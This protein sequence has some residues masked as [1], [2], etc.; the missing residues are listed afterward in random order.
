MYTEITAQIEFKNGLVIEDGELILGP[1]EEPHELEDKIA[2]IQT[3]L[4]DAVAERAREDLSWLLQSTAKWRPNYLMAPAVA[5]HADGS[6]F[7]EIELKLILI[8]NELGRLEGMNHRN[9]KSVTVWYPCD[10]EL[11]DRTF[12]PPADLPAEL[13]GGWLLDIVGKGVKP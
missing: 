1:A 10:G 5:Y 6:P 13:S 9:V 4:A 12:E 3:A 2:M 11:K 7:N 8:S